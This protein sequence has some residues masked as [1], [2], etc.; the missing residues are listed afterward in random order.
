[1]ISTQ[2]LGAVPPANSPC[3]RYL[4]LSLYISWIAN[5]VISEQH[6][7]GEL[8][9]E[10]RTYHN[11]IRFKFCDENSSANWRWVFGKCYGMCGIIT[12]ITRFMGPTWGPPGSYRPQMGPMLV[13]WTLPSGYAHSYLL[14]HQMSQSFRWLPVER[15]QLLFCTLAAL[16][17]NSILYLLVSVSIKTLLVSQ[18]WI[19]LPY[20]RW[21][22]FK[23][24]C[25]KLFYTFYKLQQ[26]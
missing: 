16:K 3:F 15:W 24:C 23:V 9:E 26:D 6:R 2:L 22:I 13:P 7:C 18:L 5:S 10:V 8:P 19:I 20:E 4:K 14:F 21:L 25:W 12:Q 17:M 11:N 1:M